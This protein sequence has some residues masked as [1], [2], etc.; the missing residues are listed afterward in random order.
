M[1][2]RLQ[3]ALEFANYRQT[4]NNQLHK[5]KVQ[6]EN[7][8][9]IAKNGGTFKIDHQL[10]SFLHSLIQDSVEE[11]NMLDINN[12]PVNISD[13]KEFHNE[14]KIRYFEVVNDYMQE[15]Q[16]IR[17]ARNVKTILDIKDI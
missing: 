9:T 16:T 3:K 2:E 10:I 14:V 11:V 7:L 6:T 17:K 8:L 1:E 12:I 4:L 13:V 15:Y 5:A